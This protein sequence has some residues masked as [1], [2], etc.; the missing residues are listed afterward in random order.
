MRY[1]VLDRDELRGIIEDIIVPLFTGSILLPEDAPSNKSESKVALLN[2]SRC[3]RIK[4][5]KADNYRIGIFREQP[6]SIYDKSIISA[7]VEELSGYHSIPQKYKKEIL[8]L[9]VEN[10]IA[11]F[12]S[13][14]NE[15]SNIIMQIVRELRKWAGRMYEGR[16]VS[17]GIE[18]VVS[19]EKAGGKENVLD[20]L[21]KDFFALLSDGIDSLVIRCL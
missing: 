8:V 21:D 14:E 13:G 2:G 16:D 11:K 7:I 9:Y 20:S 4:V 3:I 10:A 15:D 1:D 18:L 19:D 5:D 12:L 17:F 6:F